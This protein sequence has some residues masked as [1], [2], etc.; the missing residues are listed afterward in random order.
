MKEEER[1]FFDFALFWDASTWGT[2]TFDELE[3]KLG[4]Y[5]YGTQYLSLYHIQRLGLLL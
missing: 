4:T 5:T 3:L 2:R 1:V